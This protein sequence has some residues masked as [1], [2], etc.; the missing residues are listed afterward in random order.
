MIQNN[1]VPS[2]VNDSNGNDKGISRQTSFLSG[3]TLHLIFVT[4][5]D[6]I[7]RSAYMTGKTPVLPLFADS[8][9]AGEVYLG[10]ISSISAFTGV[11]LKPVIGTLSDRQGRR[12]WLFIGAGFFVLMPFVY[13]FITTPEQLVAVRLIHGLATAIYGPVT[14]AMVVEMA[15]TNRASRVGIFSLGRSGGYILGPALGGFLLLYMSAAD[16]YTII[17]LMSSVALIPLVMLPETSAAFKSKKVKP[18]FWKQFVENMR[19]S[20][21]TSAVWI[22]SGFEAMNYMVTYSAKAFLPIYALAVGRNALE[23]GLFFSVQQAVAMSLKPLFGWL[24]D[25]WSHINI[26][27][28]AVLGMSSALF[29]LT[30]S[31]NLAAFFA[32]AVL[33]GCTE[34][35][36]IPSATALLAH[37]IND[38]SIGTGLGFVGSL[39]NLAKVG[40][41]II[42]G[43]IIAFTSYE[44][45]FN[46]LGVVMLIAAFVLLYSKWRGLLLTEK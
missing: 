32:A 36:I 34:A 11:I 9:G 14:M 44:A 26:I 22:S 5:V 17:G 15:D 46:I 19:F 33:L 4:M 40:G 43:F 7:V 13:R 23:A 2:I 18:N 38:H 25:R 41:P 31:A 45:T 39:R 20:A 12:W 42:A 3:V 37:Q 6:F 10:F 16:V 8:L 35:M 24:S 1:N 28:V 21:T 27:F 30:A 29:M